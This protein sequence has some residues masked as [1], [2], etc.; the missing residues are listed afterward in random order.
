MTASP[1]LSIGLPTFNG[2]RFLGP[3][4]RSL[5]HQDFADFELIISDNGSSDDTE[6]ICRDAAAADAR[7]RFRRVEENRGAGW[8]YN[9]VLARARGEHFKWA[10]DDD[11]CE[12]SFFRQC[13]EPLRADAGLVVSYPRTILIDEV[14]TPIGPLDDSDLELRST[15]PVARLAQLLAHRVEWHPVFGVIRTDVLRRTRGIGSFVYADIALLAE[16]ALLGRFHQVPEPLFLRRYHEGRSGAANPEF[17]AHLAWYD[18]P[19]GRQRAVLPNARLVRELLRRVREAPLSPA[20]AGPR[21]RGGHG[22]VGAAPLAA[23]RRRGGRWHSARDGRLPD[24][25]RRLLP[26]VVTWPPGRDRR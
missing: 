16:L 8:N 9:A 20:R 11:V 18:P 22:A 13:L 12:P 19:L 3:T 26:S 21:H 24:Q 1:P 10:A 25:T 4:L 17:V 23:H 15:D 7:V 2:A 14:D 6:A 5:L